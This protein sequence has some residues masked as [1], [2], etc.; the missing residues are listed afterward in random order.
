ML[1]I[2]GCLI[3]I[4]ISILIFCFFILFVICCFF[5][6]CFFKKNIIHILNI[7]KDKETNQR[8]QDSLLNNNNSNI[9]RSK[10]KIFL[11]NIY[12]N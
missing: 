4:Q 10:L 9:G 11:E 6:F 1:L 5:F 12:Q 2:L 8:N 3:L 7:N